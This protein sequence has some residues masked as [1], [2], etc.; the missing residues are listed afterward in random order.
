[1]CH[2]CVTELVSGEVDYVPEPLEAP[3]QGQI[4]VCCSRPTTEVVLD[5]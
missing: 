2:T 1:M 3:E 5:L 4:L